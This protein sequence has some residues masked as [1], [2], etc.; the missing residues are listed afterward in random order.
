MLCLTA[1]AAVTT[2]RR[3]AAAGNSEEDAVQE[4][5]IDLPPEHDRWASIRHVQWHMHCLMWHVAGSLTRTM[6]DVLI[7]FVLA[8]T[9]STLSRQESCSM[10]PLKPQPPVK[11]QW[12]RSPHPRTHTAAPGYG[13][14]SASAQSAA[15]GRW[16]CLSTP[17][18]CRHDNGVTIFE[19]L[20]DA[21]EHGGALMVSAVVRAPPEACFHVRGLRQHVCDPPPS[22]C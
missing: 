8:V 12:L 5:G 13:L 10:A 7:A 11:V 15:G 9:F 1:Q 22:A 19:E 17:S 14:S 16:V 20:D 18:W 3:L 2:D 21:G 4:P 6:G